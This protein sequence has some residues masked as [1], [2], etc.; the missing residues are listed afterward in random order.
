[1]IRVSFNIE[2]TLS[3]KKIDFSFASLFYRS[4]VKPCFTVLLAARSRYPLTHYLFNYLWS[5]EIF[6]RS[7]FNGQSLIAL[8]IRNIIK[9]RESSSNH[10]V[11]CNV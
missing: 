6:Y 7:E 5:M 8:T 10:D 3:V 9:N 2:E 11:R 1:M 4:P